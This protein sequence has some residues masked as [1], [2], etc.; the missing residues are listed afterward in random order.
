MFDLFANNIF[1]FVGS[2]VI[3]IF[4]WRLSSR[5]YNIRV[6]RAMRISIV[7]LVFPIIYIHHGIL[8]LQIWT[9]LLMYIE[10]F[11]W[12]GLMILLG[13][14]AMLIVVSEALLQKQQSDQKKGDP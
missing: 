13:I 2:Y 1:I 6:R 7:I 14:W 11:I 10:Q 4:L 8:F 3:A 9:G 12:D 5:L